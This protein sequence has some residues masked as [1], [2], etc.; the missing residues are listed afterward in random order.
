M[1]VEVQSSVRAIKQVGKSLQLLSTCNRH[2]S[3][4]LEVTLK[5]PAS[6]VISYIVNLC[7]V[8]MVDY[9]S[10]TRVVTKIQ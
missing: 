5:A 9:R 4:C 1:C 3:V 7:P 8:M 10:S 2:N 6:V